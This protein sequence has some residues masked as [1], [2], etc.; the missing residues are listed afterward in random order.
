MQELSGKLILGLE[1]GLNGGSVS[2]L[3]GRKQ[4]DYLAGIGNLSRSED[5]L[6]IT[7]ELLRRNGIKKKDIG[8][9]AV[10]DEPG[11]LTGIRIGLSTA[12]GLCD[13]LSA[14]VCRISLLKAFAVLSNREGNVLSAVFSKRNGFYFAEYSCI[15]GQWDISR[16]IS[17]KI[18]LSGFTGVIDSLSKEDINFVFSEEVCENLLDFFNQNKGFD[19]SRVTKIK[20]NP[21]EILGLS[22]EKMCV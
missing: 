11:S 21:A 13:S 16:A 7:E 4:I 22:I 14:K 18:E 15:D 12:K 3:R 9:I 10:S 6:V 20:G 2:I 1:T 8:L 19:P 17:N 5:L